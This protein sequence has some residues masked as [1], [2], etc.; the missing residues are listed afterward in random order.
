MTM[1]K[2]FSR[3]QAAFNAWSGLPP[4]ERTAAAILNS[5]DFDF[6]E[7][8]DSVTIA[9]SR[10]HIQTYYDTKDIGTFPERL[11]P[12]SFHCQLTHRKDVIGFNEIFARLSALTLAV[13]APLSYVQPSRLSQY[14]E[15]YDP[16]ADITHANLKQSG[17]EKGIQALMT[18]NLLKR[19]ES[20]VHSFRLTLQ[21]LADNH[22]HTLEKLTAFKE[23]GRDTTFADV[24]PAFA[25]TEPD[26]EGEFPSP[27]DAQIG[28]NVQIK[29]SDMDLPR[30][31]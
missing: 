4:Q 18:V 3:A 26:D 24:S 9:R 21:S 15:L 8:L 13:Y 27:D 20:S 5:L 7:L 28:N 1:D 16:D 12:L 19:L 22:S 31:E 17:R 25:D 23:T 29:L 10:R 11:K 14:E 30:W 6:F 2:I